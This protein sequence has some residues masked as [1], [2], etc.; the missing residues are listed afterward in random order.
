MLFSILSSIVLQLMSK[1]LLMLGWWNL[2]IKITHI[3]CPQK[4]FLAELCFGW[5]KKDH[6]PFYDTS[7]IYWSWNKRH[8]MPLKFPFI[9]ISTSPTLNHISELRYILIIQIYFLLALLYITNSD[10]RRHLGLVCFWFWFI[11]GAEMLFPRV[12]SQSSMLLT[13][14]TVSRNTFVK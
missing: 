6:D 10:R 4:Y 14:M 8:K 12:Q 5:Q 7:K 11:F 1:Q 3:I 9:I 2:W 13:I